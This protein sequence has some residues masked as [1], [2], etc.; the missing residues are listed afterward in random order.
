MVHIFIFFFHSAPP[1][2][3]SNGIA[4][5]HCGLAELLHNNAPNFKKAIKHKRLLNRLF[6]VW[7]DILVIFG[8]PPQNVMDTQYC[9]HTNYGTLIQSVNVS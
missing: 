8:H 1:L 2:R 7:W 6:V 4:L 5:T 9:N 3:I